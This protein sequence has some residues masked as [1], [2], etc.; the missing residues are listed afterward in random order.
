MQADKIAEAQNKTRG[1]QPKKYNKT[2]YKQYIEANG[3]REGMI[4][5]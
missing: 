1:V 4:A 5:G 3:L 2:I